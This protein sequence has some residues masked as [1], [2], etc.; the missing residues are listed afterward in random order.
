MKEGLH[1]RQNQYQLSL[2]SSQANLSLSLAQLSPSLFSYN[3]L[4]HFSEIGHLMTP[5]G[6]RGNKTHIR[7]FL[8]CFMQRDVLIRSMEPKTLTS[9]TEH[10]TLIAR[11]RTV[12][13]ITPFALACTAVLHCK[14]IWLPALPH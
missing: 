14:S 6:L 13:W 11:S 2:S 7:L 3:V 12:T 8:K 1:G 10:W 9:N 5:I 4:F